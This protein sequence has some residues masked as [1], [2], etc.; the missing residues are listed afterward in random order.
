MGGAGLRFVLAGM[1]PEQHEGT[2]RHFED[3]FQLIRGEK[4]RV[5]A[6]AILT[7]LLKDGRP[8][9]RTTRYV[10][11]NGTRRRIAAKENTP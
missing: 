6:C 11:R 9:I 8:D 7:G 2:S 1:T 3:S 10:W 5:V 4:P